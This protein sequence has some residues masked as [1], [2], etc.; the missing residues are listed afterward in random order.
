MAHS[1]LPTREWQRTANGWRSKEHL[2]AIGDTFADAS[3]WYAH[4]KGLQLW[5][6]D[7]ESPPT[8]REPMT[9]RRLAGLLEQY[10]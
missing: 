10:A 7:I 8:D 1:N 5:A 6:N 9:L 2:A 3:R 4:K